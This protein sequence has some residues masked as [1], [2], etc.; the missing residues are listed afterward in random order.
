MNTNNIV[1]RAIRTTEE[2]VTNAMAQYFGDKQYVESL[3]DLF[4]TALIHADYNVDQT[5]IERL[6]NTMGNGTGYYDPMIRAVFLDEEG[7]PVPEFSSI[8]I[9][10]I[11]T[12]RRLYV[13][14]LSKCNNVIIHDHH[15]ASAEDTVRLVKT[16]RGESKVISMDPCWVD[17][18]TA[19]FV[20]AANL[21]GFDMHR[22]SITPAAF[23]PKWKT[24]N[25][26][27][28][29]SSFLTFPPAREEVLAEAQ[30]D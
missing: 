24:D 18:V 11:A 29:M 9:Q 16:G 5:Q 6:G 27:K 7:K 19:D 10:D 17:G 25:W 22:R 15:A 14:V 3:N 20:N 30:D 1:L 28:Q 23:V 8:A 26:F 2:S 13:I 21:F 4:G 12:K